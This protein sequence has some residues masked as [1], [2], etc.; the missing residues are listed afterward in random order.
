MPAATGVKVNYNITDYHESRSGICEMLL[1]LH[2]LLVPR[3]TV[4]N[5]T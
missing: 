5:N 2:F 3:E 1:L 4:Q